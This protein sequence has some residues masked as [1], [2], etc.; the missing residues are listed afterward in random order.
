MKP[1]SKN[2]KLIAWLAVDALDAREAATLRDHLAHCDGCRHYWEEISQVTTTLTVPPPNSNL[3]ASASFHRRVTE[4]LSAAEPDPLL[5][6]LAVGF[7]KTMLGWRTVVAALAVV[8]ITLVFITLPT[9]QSNPI[10][11]T[12]MIQPRL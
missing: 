2:R 7:W 5:T 3:E 4:K 10:S 1:C 12:S 9:R 6:Y 8:I 11:S